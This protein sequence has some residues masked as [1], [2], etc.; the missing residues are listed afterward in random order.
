M[1]IA[2]K[3][4]VMEEDVNTPLGN[5]SEAVTPNG[6][7]ITQDIIGDEDN[8]ESIC[9]YNNNPDETVTLNAETAETCEKDSNLKKRKLRIES[10]QL[11]CGHPTCNNEEEVDM[12]LCSVCRG[13]FHYMCTKLPPYQ[14]ARFNSQGYRKFICEGCVNIPK[15]LVEKCKYDEANQTY[16]KQ[17]DEISELK[18]SLSAKHKL[19]ES[20]QLALDTNKRLVEEKDNLISNQKDIIASLKSDKYA[21]DDE[22]R[23]FLAEK[24]KELDRCVLEINTMK[25]NAPHSREL[26]EIKEMISQKDHALLGQLKAIEELSIDV[27]R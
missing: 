26:S 25:Q 17:L 19:N 27:Q 21:P 18:V 7:N 10:G 24:E 11:K 20:L 4:L 1:S 9:F 6:T 2:H 12:L 13:K 16:Q 22:C 8:N 5:K 3:I 15:D 23:K 14:I